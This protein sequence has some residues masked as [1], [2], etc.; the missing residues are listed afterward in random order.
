MKLTSRIV[1]VNHTWIFSGKDALS[2]FEKY[3]RASHL[4]KGKI[5]ILTDSNTREYCLPLLLSKNPWLADSHFLTMPLG[6]DNK[7]LETTS[8][9]WLEMMSSQAGRDALMITLGGGMV[10]DLGGFTAAG[11]KRGIPCIH[12]PTTLLG[13]VDAAIGGKTA[14]NVNQIKNQI[15]FF[16]PPAAVFIY[17]EFLCTLPVLQIRSGLAEIIKTS[18][19][20][21]PGLWNRIKQHPV[22]QLIKTS[23]DSPL[24]QHLITSAITYKNQIIARDF[25]E[26]KTRAV[27]NFGH[28]IGHA[29]ESASHSSGNHPLL[30]GD[31]VAM[32]MICAAWLS[33]HKTG[34]P[35]SERDGIVKY[36]RHGYGPVPPDYDPADLIERMGHDKKFRESRIRFTLLEKLGSPKINVVCNPD[37]INA[38]L[39]FYFQTDPSSSNESEM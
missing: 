22:P 6:E 27:L 24:W 29:V 11:Y 16:Y 19:T 37:E 36:I 5:F 9:L 21:N 7:T 28:T 20:G 23:L 38:A 8:R 39:K 4:G 30:H 26:K 13:Q 1:Q 2:Q 32:G 18:L 34:L 17:P 15:G 25:T 35:V 33:S 14:V 10:T 3:C 12:I 31:A